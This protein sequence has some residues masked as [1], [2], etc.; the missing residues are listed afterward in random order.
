VGEHRLWNNYSTTITDTHLLRRS[1]L[2][3]LLF[4]STT[5]GPVLPIYPAKSFT[6]LGVKMYNDNQP[7]YYLTV[8]GYWGTMNTSDTNDFF[9]DEYQLNNTVRWT[10]GKHQITWAEKAAGQAETW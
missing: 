4:A 6:D 9:R 1:R 3:T 10:K 5:N 7:Q 8:A 2:T